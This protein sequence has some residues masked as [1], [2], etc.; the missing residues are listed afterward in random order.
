MVVEEKEELGEGSGLPAA[1]EE[2]ERRRERKEGFGASRA[3]CCCCSMGGAKRTRFS[4][5]LSTS[6]CRSSI[7]TA[8]SWRLWPPPARRAAGVALLRIIL[9]P[10]RLVSVSEDQRESRQGRSSLC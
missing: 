3:G 2:G 8:L 10:L 7:S 4:W 6:T 1:V 9:R 5:D